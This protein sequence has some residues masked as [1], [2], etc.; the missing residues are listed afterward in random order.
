M[1]VCWLEFH[2]GNGGFWLAY[3]FKRVFSV[4]LSFSR[5]SLCVWLSCRSFNFHCAP[6]KFFLSFFIRSLVYIYRKLSQRMCCVCRFFLSLLD[7]SLTQNMQPFSGFFCWFRSACY[8]LT[9]FPYTSHM[10]VLEAE[11]CHQK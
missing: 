7:H 9:R 10:C 4:L 11:L 6:S 2:S 8:N 5:F 3:N 1:C